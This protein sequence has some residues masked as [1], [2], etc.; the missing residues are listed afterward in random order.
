MVKFLADECVF[1]LTVRFLRD[2]GWDVTTVTELGLRGVNDAQ[3]MGKAQEMKAVLITRDM[4]FADIR[5]FPPSAY[6]G[7]IVLKMSY[8]TSVQ[9]HAVLRKMLQEV[10]E[11]EF[12]GALFIVNHNKWRKR[13]RP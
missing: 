7:V 11:D 2:E 6:G 1:D 8:R 13:R 5:K 10:K 4:D 9:V 12:V 3:V